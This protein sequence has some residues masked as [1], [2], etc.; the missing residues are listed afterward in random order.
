MVP[1][2]ASGSCGGGSLKWLS[3]AEAVPAKAAKLSKG[4]IPHTVASTAT[5]RIT[6]E[7]GILW[8]S[9][10]ARGAGSGTR[11]PVNKKAF[12][13]KATHSARKHIVPAIRALAALSSDG[14]NGSSLHDPVPEVQLKVVLQDPSIEP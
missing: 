3:G 7:P 14:S 6:S 8:V 4:T 1:S 2:R 10:G 11:W 9:T 12:V 13:A 5:A